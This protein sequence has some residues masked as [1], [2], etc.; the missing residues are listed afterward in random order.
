MQITAFKAILARRINIRGC[1]DYKNTFARIES[2]CTLR[3]GFK[4]LLKSLS[5]TVFDNGVMTT[6]KRRILSFVFTVLCFKKSLLIKL[7]LKQ[8]TSKRDCRNKSHKLSIYSPEPRTEIYCFKLNFN[9]SNWS[10]NLP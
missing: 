9:I 4:A 8:N 2:D 3:F 1:E 7:N 6:P 5:Y 10:I